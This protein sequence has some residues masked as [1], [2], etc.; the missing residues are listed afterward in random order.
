MEY[1][2]RDI[3]MAEAVVDLVLQEGGLGVVRH[4]DSD[5]PPQT[6][7]VKSQGVQKGLPSWDATDRSAVRYHTQ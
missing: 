3:V 5:M 4:M 6:E 1:M 7:Q 2:Q